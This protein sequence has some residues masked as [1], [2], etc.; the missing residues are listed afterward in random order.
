MRQ[1]GFQCALGSVY[2]YDA[3][4]PSARVS[5]AFVLAHAR[6][7]AII[8]LHDGGARGRRTLNTLRRVLPE[9]R[10]RGLRVM[11]LSELAALAPLTRGSI[12]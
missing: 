10:R 2:P 8:V 5:S 9:L 11:T 12:E 3:E 6:P 4:V 7:G 1:R